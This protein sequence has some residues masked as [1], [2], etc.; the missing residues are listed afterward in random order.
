MSCTLCIIHTAKP[1]NPSRPT[2]SGLIQG[3]PTIENLVD[4]IEL[5]L[6]LRVFNTITIREVIIE[7]YYR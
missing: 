7:L 5:A 4:A 2:I 3:D 1:R 6:L